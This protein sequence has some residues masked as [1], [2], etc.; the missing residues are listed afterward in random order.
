[1]LAIRAGCQYLKKPYLEGCTLYVTLEPCPMCA[2]ALSFARLKRLVWGGY[3][4]KGG[5]VIHGPMIF[6]RSTA[7]HKPDCLGGVQ[8]ERCKE[9]LKRFFEERR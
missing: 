7:F 1:M 8:E 3:N 9:L 2:Q 5:G 4:P 6:D